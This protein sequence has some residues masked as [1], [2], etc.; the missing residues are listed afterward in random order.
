VQLIYCLSSRNIIVKTT[1]PRR[2]YYHTGIAILIVLLT[3]INQIRAQNN[4]AEL[5]KL[6]QGIRVEMP[7]GLGESDTMEYTFI[8]AGCYC[9]I[10]QATTG[11]KER[12][13]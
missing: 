5:K 8:H 2:I 7:S 1:L 13:N 9:S 10:S 11:K 4:F 3:G 12:M 6:I